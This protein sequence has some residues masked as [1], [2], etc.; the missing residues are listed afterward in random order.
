MSPVKTIPRYQNSYRL[1]PY[2]RFEP[3]AVDKILR[4]V[5]EKKLPILTTYQHQLVTRLAAEISTEVLR[6]ISRK[7]YDRCKVIVQVNI[8]QRQFQSAHVAFKCLWDVER[9]NYSYY[10]YESHAVYAWVCVFGLYYE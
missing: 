5:M 2:R 6:A 3:E 4:D 7:D 8:M 1:E 9:D 10:V